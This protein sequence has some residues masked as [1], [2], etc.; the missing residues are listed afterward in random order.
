MDLIRQMSSG[1]E[2]N[3]GRV[4]ILGPNIDKRFDMSDRIPLNSTR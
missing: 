3:N 1:Q 2:N 4:N